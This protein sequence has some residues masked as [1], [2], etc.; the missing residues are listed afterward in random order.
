[1]DTTN[2]PIE[3]GQATAWT[4]QEV[5]SS[6]RFDQ[7]P[8]TND[9]AKTIAAIQAG[10]AEKFATAGDLEST[11]RLDEPE[12]ACLNAMKQDFDR[13][14]VLIDESAGGSAYK[15]ALQK[16]KNAGQTWE[17][18][19][20]RLLANE[21]TLLKKA[22]E[23]SK[24]TGD[25]EGKGAI[26]VGVYGNG[27]LAIRQRSQEIVNA[28]WTKDWKDGESDKGDLRLLFHPEATAQE[29][30]RW[31]KPVE[32]VRAVKA[33]GY[34][35]SADAPDHNKKG[36]VAAFEAVTGSYYVMSPNGRDYREAILECP[37]DLAD[38]DLVRI[39][40]FFPGLRPSLVDDGNAYG[41]GDLRGA[42]LW[43]RG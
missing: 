41:R 15:Q 43:L 24:L 17:A 12:R 35:V 22:V 30:G 33:A 16:D 25:Q 29:K 32:I 34:H 23:L 39:V 7:M 14:I 18:I 28:R 10:A 9:P 42:M 11:E 21:A 5:N 1:M 8:N 13:G 27:E 6:D 20:G 2:K 37:D 38:E 19:Q 40:S 31:A 4:S 3:D 36:P 26:L